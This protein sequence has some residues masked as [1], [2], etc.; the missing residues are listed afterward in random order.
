M[1]TRRTQVWAVGGVAVA[2]VLVTTVLAFGLGHR[3]GLAT[4]QFVRRPAPTFV[5]PGLDRR[6]QRTVRL[7]QLRGHVVVVNFWASW[8]AECRA[9]QAALNRTWQRYRDA[10]VV[11]VGVNFQD[12][13]GDARQ[14]AAT[15]GGSYP[16]V[17]T[18]TPRRP[19]P[20][21]SGAFR[22]RTWST[23]RGGSW[24]AS[25]A[26]SPTRSC[27]DG[28]TGHVQGGPM[29]KRGWTAG[30]ALVVDALLAALVALAAVALADRSAR[31]T[32]DEQAHDIAAALHCP[33]CK[34]LSAADSP[35]PLA[36]QMRAQIRN[37]W[38]TAPRRSRSARGSSRRTGPRC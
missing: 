5:L 29:T 16:V 32:T 21:G 26:R 15:S 37:S 14:Y 24:T 11:V 28:S 4:G 13:A 33:V 7:A 20:T 2:V 35:A 1:A 25:S 3:G 22:R 34:D 8:C 36:R 31:P 10:G 9:E 18:A 17:V 23:P 30:D 38:P 27:P 12:A 6:T 19:S